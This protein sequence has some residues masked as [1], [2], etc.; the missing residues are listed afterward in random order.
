MTSQFS[1]QLVKNIGH[2]VSGTHHTYIITVSLLP[3]IFPLFSL[4]ERFS[5][6]FFLC[7]FRLP[8]TNFLP[9]IPTRLSSVARFFRNAFRTCGRRVVF[10][11]RR[12]FNNRVNV[13]S[14]RPFF[15]CLYSSL[16]FFL[17]AH[18][19][20]RNVPPAIFELFTGILNVRVLSVWRIILLQIYATFITVSCR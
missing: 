16:F 2:Q 3:V 6:S 13:R 5:F 14:R 20:Y 19:R 15:D 1:Q 10:R 17:G 7:C 18:K 8:R 11:I 4:G 9:E 12:I